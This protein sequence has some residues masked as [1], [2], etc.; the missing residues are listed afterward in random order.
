MTAV[1]QLGKPY[2]LWKKSSKRKNF[3]GVPDSGL[4]FKTCTVRLD[5]SGGCRFISKNDDLITSQVI[6][7]RQVDR[8]VEI[9]TK[10]SVYVLKEICQIAE[11]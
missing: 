3:N 9:E 2:E 6:D 10:N 5:P 8:E 4:I 11:L 1:V 7:V